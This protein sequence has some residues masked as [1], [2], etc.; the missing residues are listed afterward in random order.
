MH[1]KTIAISS[2]KFSSNVKLTYLYIVEKEVH[3]QRKATR[4]LQHHQGLFILLSIKDKPKGVRAA[5]NSCRSPGCY[6]TIGYK[7]SS[8]SLEFICSPAPSLIWLFLVI[9]T[10]FLLHLPTHHNLS[11]F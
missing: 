11:L 7:V 2:A 5:E 6:Q 1:K 10:H 9:I 3:A 8:Y 4:F